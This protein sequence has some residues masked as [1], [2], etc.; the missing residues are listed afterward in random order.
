MTKKNRGLLN[1]YN[2]ATAR[3][4]WDV[5]T[6]CSAEK[7]KAF[8]D[9]NVKQCQMNGYDARICSAN[10]YQFTYAFKYV[11]ED[12]KECLFYRTAANDYTFVIE[13]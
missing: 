2:N 13:D 12:N 10:T 8:D 11:N 1:N 4:L 7:R 3:T 5:Y 6:T 9:C